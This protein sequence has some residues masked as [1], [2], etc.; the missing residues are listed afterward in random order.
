MNNA[1][2]SAIG[3]VIMLMLAAFSGPIG[4]APQKLFY[5]VFPTFITS[6]PVSVTFYNA[7]PPNGN[8]TINSLSIGVGAGNVSISAANCAANSLGTGTLTG[9]VCVITNFPGIPTAGN[10][11]FTLPITITPSNAPCANTTWVVAANTGNAFPQGTPFDPVGAQMQLSSHCDGILACGGSFTSGAN[12][13]DPGTV[14][15]I[16]GLFN[17]YGIYYGSSGCTNVAYAN[18]FLDSNPSQSNHFA[19][20]TGS[21]PNGAFSYTI[22]WDPA[23]LSA[24][25]LSQNPGQWPN[26]QLKVSWA[27]NPT[28]SQYELA[29]ACLGPVTTTQPYGLPAPY[30]KF[31]SLTDATHIVIDVASNVAGES[32]ALPVTDSAANF[33]IVIGGERMQVTAV[34]AVSSGSRYTLT[35]VRAQGGTTQ[36]N[37]VYLDHVMYTLMPIYPDTNAYPNYRGK[38]AHMCVADQEWIPSGLDPVTG[39]LKIRYFS[40]IVDIG[41]GWVSFD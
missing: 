20:D 12:T 16:R 22:N 5:A 17:N 31:Y 15:G 21:Q 26:K 24:P 34:S 6:S 9:G 1:L 8:S 28:P 38:Q 33:P 18:T 19:W 7:S 11:A 2:R 36:Y 27:S 37:P 32:Y 35:V 30:G 3:S 10:R 13:T 25:S 39:N 41:D 23:P 4:A 14:F 40:T 29:L